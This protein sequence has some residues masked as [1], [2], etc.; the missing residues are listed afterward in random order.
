M[1]TIIGLGKAGCNIAKAF[2]KYPQYKV[3]TV[4]TSKNGAYNHLSVEKQDNIENYEKNCPDLSDFLKFID[5]EVLFVTSGASEVSAMSLS[6]LQQIAHKCKISILYVSPNTDLL[7]G[8]KKIHERAVF[9][10]FQEYARSGV[11][12]RLYIVENDNIE[13][14]IGEMSILELHDKINEVIV[15]TIHMI[16]VFDNSDPIVSTFTNPHNISRICTLGI[17]DPDSKEDKMFFKL[18]NMR[19][20]R[21]YYA[22]PKRALEVDKTLKQ[23]IVET[24]QNMND[25]GKL[26]VS[27]GVFPTN[28][29]D[30]YLYTVSYSSQIQKNEKST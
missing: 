17:V 9:N 24:V 2:E 30:N 8:D 11:F 29:A 25:E 22:V 4:D 19:E 5:G 1:D 20:K 3:Y 18:E 10:V 27:Y 15:T 12:K 28:Y 23:R 26:F 13:E 7:G 6:M 16:N 21:L 14:I